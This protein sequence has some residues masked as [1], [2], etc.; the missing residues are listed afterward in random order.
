MQ[1]AA[2]ARRVEQKRRELEVA[3]RQVHAWSVG[4]EGERLVA[5]E[6]ETLEATGWK[7][8]HDVHWPGRPR[9]NLD[10][11]LIGPGGVIVVDAKNWSGRVEVRHGALRCN[12]RTKSS[13]C[14]GA[15]AA[16]AAVSA[17]L[18]ARHRAVVASAL[19]FVQQDLSPVV[20]GGVTVCGL[21]QIVRWCQER[22]QVLSPAETVQI[23]AYL[24]GLLSGAASPVQ[25]T[26]AHVVNGATAPRGMPAR[27]ERAAAG[28]EGR[29][30]RSGKPR[31]ASSGTTQP[32]RRPP[33]RRTEGFG[34]NVAKL[35][36]LGVLAVTAPTWIPALTGVL[37]SLSGSSMESV[38]EPATTPPPPA[39]PPAPGP[40]PTP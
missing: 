29:K 2:A 38:T 37:T 9:A 3:E 10:H 36:V 22:A 18:E 13:A 7:L 40:A 19:C 34:A 23:T 35:V 32:R 20:A 12:G 1:A 28:P 26:A 11:L 21:R 24:D 15:A 30:T 27:R 5:A 4:A 8:L 33:S 25:L 39:A 16:T 14:E 17:L 31:G 6:L